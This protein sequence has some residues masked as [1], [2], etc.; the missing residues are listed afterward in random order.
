ME[1]EFP[2]SLGSSENIFFPVTFHETEKWLD[3]FLEHRFE[4][5]GIYEDSLVP[6]QSWLYHSILTPMLNIGLITPNEIVERTLIFVEKKQ[7]VKSQ[8]LV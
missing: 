2:Y 5:F 3:D 7:K 1:R 8:L 4:K 6:E